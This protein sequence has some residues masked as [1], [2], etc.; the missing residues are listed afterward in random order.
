[1]LD[2]AVSLVLRA[3][4]AAQE[5]QA[6]H[7]AQLPRANLLDFVRDG[8]GHYNLCHFWSNFELGDLRFFRSRA[9]LDFFDFLDRCGAAL[10]AG[11]G[12]LSLSLRCTSC[13]CW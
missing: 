3:C 12:C 7:S 2:N 6:L 9:Y 5:F 1:M 13:C 4:T 11:R 10:P 8:E